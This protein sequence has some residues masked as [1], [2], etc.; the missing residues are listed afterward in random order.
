MKPSDIGL[1]VYR[2]Q[3]RNE[4]GDW[5]MGGYSLARHEVTDPDKERY[6]QTEDVTDGIGGLAV[7]LFISESQREAFVA[8]LYSAGDTLAGCAKG[9]ANIGCPGLIKEFD[10]RD[11]FIGCTRVGD[12]SHIVV[13][14]Y[15]EMSVG[16]AAGEGTKPVVPVFHR[17]SK[18][19]GGHMTASP[20]FLLCFVDNRAEKGEAAMGLWAAMDASGESQITVSAC[21]DT[22]PG[23][24][25]TVP[26]IRVHHHSDNR[27][28][29]QL[30]KHSPLEH[31]LVPARHVKFKPHLMQNGMMGFIV[32]DEIQ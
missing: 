24:A 14:D 22:I 30:Y 3:F 13:F 29:F 32:S 31:F 26:N 12:P 6:E 20:E 5:E 1:A 8:G 27:W 23:G 16:I 11:S 15:R 21:L 17:D 28:L 9:E 19:Y 10:D 25:K 18:T 7:Y 2:Y 4:I